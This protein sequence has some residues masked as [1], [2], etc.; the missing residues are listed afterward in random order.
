MDIIK[1]KNYYFDFTDLVSFA[2]IDKEILYELLQDGR[3][4]SPFLERYIEQQFSLEWISGC[5]DH[6][7]TDN[8]GNKYDAKNFTKNGLKFMPSNQIGAGRSFDQTIAYDKANDLTYICCDIV[9][10]PKVTIRF[11]DGCDLIKEYPKCSVPFKSRKEL[12]KNT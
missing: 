8:N 11:I 2:D 4:A 6:D 1:N 10:F 12:F 3:T 7:H 5:K 9:D